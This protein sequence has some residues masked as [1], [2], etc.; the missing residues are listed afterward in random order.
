MRCKRSH[1]HRLGTRTSKCRLWQI[2]AVIPS[3]DV[4]RLGWKPSTG[5]QATKRADYTW[6]TS[7]IANRSR[8]EARR[9][10]GRRAHRPGA[11]YFPGTNS[12]EVTGWISQI[13]AL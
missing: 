1:K 5:L 6:P 13:V 11:R 12:I 2:A 10:F 4:A 8:A 9:P 7:T 3:E